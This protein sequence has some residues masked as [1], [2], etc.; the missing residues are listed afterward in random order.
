MEEAKLMFPTLKADAFMQ[1]PITISNIVDIIQ[2]VL[3][4]T[5]Q[6]SS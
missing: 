6:R 5:A 3:I 2:N 4:N 1:K